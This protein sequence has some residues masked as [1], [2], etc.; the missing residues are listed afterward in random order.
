[1]NAHPNPNSS[2]FAIKPN[3]LRHRGGSY[4]LRRGAM[5]PAGCGWCVPDGGKDRSVTGVPRTLRRDAV[6]LS[7][8]LSSSHTC[9]PAASWAAPPP[10]RPGAWPAPRR[11][12]APPPPTLYPKVSLTRY[13]QTNGGFETN[14]DQRIPSVPRTAMK[15]LRIVIRVWHGATENG[16]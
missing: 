6:Y 2:Q 13:L 15:I 3:H 1:M 16:P 5:L 12:H 8:K 4:L 14:G 7:P 11:G 9:A 10:P